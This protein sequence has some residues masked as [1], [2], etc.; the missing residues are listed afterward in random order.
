MIPGRIG[1]SNGVASGQLKVKSIVRQ[2]GIL[3]GELIPFVVET[4]TY[5][6]D[7]KRTGYV[8]SQAEKTPDFVVRDNLFYEQ[9]EN[10]RSQW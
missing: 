3:S 5:V 6:P 9:L 10:I 8:F 2:P 7:E 4:L 1:L